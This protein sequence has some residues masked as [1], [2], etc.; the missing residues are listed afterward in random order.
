MSYLTKAEAWGSR[1]WD[2]LSVGLWYTGRRREA[3]RAN[4]EAMRLD[5]ANERLKKNDELMRRAIMA[6]GGSQN[7]GKMV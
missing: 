4:E 1:P 5:P 2:L 6:E 7:G 3:I